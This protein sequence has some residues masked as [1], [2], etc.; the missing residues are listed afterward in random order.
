[1]ESKIL[2][3]ARK[4]Y[5][6]RL[7]VAEDTPLYKAYRYVPHQRVGSAFG[8]KTGQYTLFILVWNQVWFL[9]ELQECTKVLI[10]SIP[11]E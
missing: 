8:L 4:G 11:N 1:M 2:G 5:F 9:R 6:F 3:S 7:Q 10:V